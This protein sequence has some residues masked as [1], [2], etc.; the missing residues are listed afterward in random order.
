MK[1]SRFSKAVVL[2][3]G[4][5]PLT[6]LGWDALNGALG[7][8]PVNFAIRTTGLLSLIFL[9]L[10]LAITPASRLTHQSWLGQFRRPAGLYAFYHTAL[11]FWLFFWFF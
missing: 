10:S 3:N 11:H 9:A 8:N 1:I 2:V 6:L 4:A 7:S 5:V